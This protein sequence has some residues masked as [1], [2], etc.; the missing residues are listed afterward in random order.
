MTIDRRL[1]GR[2][3][4]RGTEP[5]VQKTLRNCTNARVRWGGAY[6]GVARVGSGLIDDQRS[7]FALSDTINSSPIIP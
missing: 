7:Y 3:R 5:L 6:A 1:H 2:R 4:A